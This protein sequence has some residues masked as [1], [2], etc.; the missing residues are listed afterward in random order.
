MSLHPAILKTLLSRPLSIADLHSGVQ[1]SLPTLRKALQDLN[2]ARWIRVVGQADTNGGR[3]AML[4]GPD[5]SYY[6]SVGVHLQLPGLHLITADLRGQVLDE[7]HD[8]TDTI[9]QPDEV[10]QRI[11]AYVSTV[12]VRFPERR[13]L[14]IGIAAPGF[15][16]PVSGDIL[17][18]GRVPSWYSLPICQRLHSALNLPIHIANDVDCMA[19]AEFQRSKLSFEQ[20]L[21][22][23]GFDEGVK[24]SL[25]LNGQLYKGSF[26]NAGLIV[27][28]LLQLGDNSE[29]ARAHDLLTIHGVND[30]VTARINAL[31]E[32]EREPYRGILETRGQRER[33]QLMQQAA[34]SG[35]PICQATA[36]ALNTA[37]AAAMANVIYMVQPDVMVVGGILS[38]MPLPLYTDLEARA[39]AYLSPLFT[40]RLV[41]QQAALSSPNRA[42]LGAVYHFLQTHLDQT[43]TDMLHIGDEG[44]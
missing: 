39:R 30:L 7:M 3:P 26:G 16:D 10:I 24:V 38:Q 22:Y 42:A 28:D 23:F 11:I 43:D 21:A 27:T 9:P 32:P 25:F 2:D 40:N 31:P 35:L 15:I 12:Q 14:G 44:G 1:V 20:N 19:F 33:F 34:A 37:L 6:L 17:S 5:D 41:I 18:I 36:Q 8:F 29:A 4:F 13:V